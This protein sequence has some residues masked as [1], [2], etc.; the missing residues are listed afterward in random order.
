MARIIV[1]PQA[2]R[3]VEAAISA[4][5]LPG[6]TW[7]RIARSLRVLEDFPLAG[8]QLEGRWAPTRSVLGPWRWMILLY[9]FDESSDRV[10]VVAMHDARSA[11]SARASQ[12]S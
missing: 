11:G 9:R 6:D 2:Q 8:S 7:V 12:N 10:F 5:E 4:L 1:T 3:D